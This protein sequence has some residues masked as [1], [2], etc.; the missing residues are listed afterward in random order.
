MDQSKDKGTGLSAI[1]I[2]VPY[3]IAV[4]RLKST[5]KVYKE[6]KEIVTSYDLYNAKIIDKQQPWIFKGEGCLSLPGKFVN[7]KR[8][9]IIKVRNGDGKILS[10]SG[11]AAVVVQHEIS[12]WD[13]KLI[14][15]CEAFEKEEQS[16]E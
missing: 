9:N 6:K 2:S 8:Y 11:F 12:H 13:G 10:F 16:C 15:D 1:Q 14:F 7:T 4:I 5:I 3:R